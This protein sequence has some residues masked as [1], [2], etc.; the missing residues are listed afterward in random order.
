[1]GEDR[2]NLRILIC[3]MFSGF[4][5]YASLAPPVFEALNDLLKDNYMCL[6]QFMGMMPEKEPVDLPANCWR[7]DRRYYDE[8]QTVKLQKQRYT[9]HK[10]YTGNLM[11]K[12]YSLNSH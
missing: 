10:V 5:A 3:D 12:Q 7:Y 4:Y 11:Q 6:G 8:L 9:S 2:K 1:M